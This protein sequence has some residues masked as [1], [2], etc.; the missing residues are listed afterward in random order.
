[1][2]KMGINI[3]RVLNNFLMLIIKIYINMSE[4]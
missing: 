4:K 1:M 2:Y 3:K